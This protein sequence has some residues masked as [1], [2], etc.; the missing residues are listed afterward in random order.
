[1]KLSNLFKLGAGLLGGALLTGCNPF[2]EQLEKDTAQEGER[3]RNLAL[4]SVVMKGALAWSTSHGGALPSPQEF[5]ASVRPTVPSPNGFNL[6]E[7][8]IQ[9]AKERFE[10]TYPGGRV[11][12]SVDGKTEV[13]RLPDPY[14]GTIAYADGN[15]ERNYLPRK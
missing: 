7:S 10:W 11:E 6:T 12:P 13:G 1:M 4:A 9:G 15:V 2:A 5:R 14:G 8:D 3:G